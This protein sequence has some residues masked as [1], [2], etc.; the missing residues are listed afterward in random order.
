MAFHSVNATE[1]YQQA[2]KKWQQKGDADKTW[3]IFKRHFAAEYHEIREQQHVQGEAV[4]NSAQLAHETTDIAAALENLALAATAERNIV[5][6]IIAINKK[7]VDIN[8]VLCVQVKSLVATNARLA[9]TQ[10]TKYQKPTRATI[11]RE[12][13]PIDPN[14]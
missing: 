2:C 1:M 13:V 8:T 14:G 11:S 4:F 5:A 9:N 3:K 7:S 10:G 6:N 12:S